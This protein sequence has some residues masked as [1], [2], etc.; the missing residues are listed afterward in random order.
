MPKA[1]R[2]SLRLNGHLIAAIAATAYFAFHFIHGDRG[3]AALL[4]ARAE[5]MTA[6]A[7]LAEAEAKRD[8][9]SSRV[10][11]LRPET[12]DADMLEEQARAL[13]NFAGARDYVL[14]TT[15][16]RS[17]TAARPMN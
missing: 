6:Q 17:M 15:P 13:L 11:L 8:A 3:A 12:L 10:A 1:K 7:E 4:E 5:L 9:L 14:E 16:K 2:R